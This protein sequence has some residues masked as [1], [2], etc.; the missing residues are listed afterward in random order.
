MNSAN[1]AGT[2]DDA[3]LL[4]TFEEYVIAS[5]SLDANRVAKYYEEPFMFVTAASTVAAAD[6]TE[7]GSFLKPGFTA[8][9]ASGYARTEFPKLR[10]KALGK[11]LAIVSGLGVC[12]KSDGTQL[13]S[14]GITYLWRQ[15]AAGW[16]LAVNDCPRPIE[17][18]AARVARSVRC[19]ARCPLAPLS[20]G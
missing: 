12:Y 5:I 3:G 16:K 17:S 9:K 15:T 7:A 1:A 8:L 10:S 6:R 18:P 20:S 19:R 14:F 11:G 2:E 4:K 13:A